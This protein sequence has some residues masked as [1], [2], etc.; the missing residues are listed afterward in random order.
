MK[1]NGGL[2]S[3]YLCLARQRGECNLPYLPVIDVECDVL[4]YYAKLGLSA[5]F[6]RFIREAIDLTMDEAQANVRGMHV[7]YRDKLR[8]LADQEERL[9]DLATDNA[10]PR[11][12]I[13]ERLRKIQIER[14]R[15]QQGLEETGER[16]A[17]GARKLQQ[18]LDLLDHPHD[19]YKGAPDEG[20]R[21]LNTASFNKLWLDD[22]GVRDDEPTAPIHEI[23]EAAR[24]FEAWDGSRNRS[25]K[26]TEVGRSLHE[27]L[28]GDP[29]EL[30]SDHLFW[31]ADIF[32]VGSSKNVLVPKA[33]LEPAR[34][35]AQEPKS[36]VSANSTTSAE[37]RSV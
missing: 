29:G 27:Q 32:R 24:A 35:G 16:L 6:L 15:A 37:R 3:Y 5:N 22:G 26:A 25:A 21:D 20:R 12:K 18:Y 28:P 4:D 36:C 34:P 17:L 30:D 9:L 19:L 23:R 7:A 8:K 11:E 1:G 31:L 13:H 33:G 2:Y 10:L 14:V